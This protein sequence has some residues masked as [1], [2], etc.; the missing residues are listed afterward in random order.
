MASRCRSRACP[1]LSAYGWVRWNRSSEAPFTLPRSPFPVLV[2]RFIW[3][4]FLPAGLAAQRPAVSP[5][6]PRLLS[7][8]QDTT[9]SV[10]LFAQPT[11][12]LDAISERATAAGARV[13]VRSS[14]LHAVSADV[15]AAA[16]RQL[17]QDR[18]LRRI[19]PLGRF[20]LR[21]PVPGRPPLDAP[22]IITA[23]SAV[24]GDTCGVTPGDDPLLGPSAMPYRQ[25]N[26][27]PLTTQGID[28]TGVRIALLDTGFDT[29]NPAFKGISITAQ[30]DFVFH[31]DTVM[32]QPGKDAPGAQSHGT[33]TWSL[34]AGDVPGRLH[35]IARGAHYLL[36]KTED[37]RSETRVEEDNYVAALQWADSIGVDIVSSSLGYLSFDNGFSYTPAQLNGDIAVTSVAAEIAAARGILVVTAAGNGGPGFRTL[38]T[39][40]D[41]DSVITAGA[42]DSLGNIAG[43]SSRGPTADG[44]LKPDLTA[45]GVAVC[46][47]NGGGTVRRESGTSFAAPILAASAALVKQLHPGLTPMALLAALRRFATNHTQPD[48]TRGWGRPDVALSAIFPTGLTALTPITSPLAS[49][50]PTFAWS[51]DSIPAFARPVQ[52]RLRIARDSALATI[53]ID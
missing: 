52:Y 18:D 37:V 38:V 44:R 9:I 30:Y 16:L 13:R 40:G 31:D 12:S 49:V 34:F 6:L 48:S 21:P 32:D 35:G 23:P 15:P 26:L 5:V 22:R 14:W 42:E 46:V 17:L 20:K 2:R 19:Q 36:A 43:F 7:R 25:L 4:V 41:A 10:W 29:S 47:V 39:P 45:P 24:P 11:A 27:R 28:A 33:A 8:V 51:A 50:T 3:L 53:V 1:R